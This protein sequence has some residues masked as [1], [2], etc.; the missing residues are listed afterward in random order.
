MSRDDHE[1]TMA[2]SVIGP[3]VSVNHYE[4]IDKIGA[5][6]MGEIFLAQD[7]RLA[8]KVA[9][10]FLPLS[11]CA[12]EL[13]KQRFIRE[14]R[15]AASL[16]HQNVITIFEVSEHDGRPFICMEYVKGKSLRQV[17]DEQTMN[18]A[19]LIDLALQICEG[20]GAAH[21]Q[22]IVHRDIKPEN[23]LLSESGKVKVLD[24]GLAVLDDDDKLTKT[25]TALGTAGYMSPEQAQGTAVDVRSDI[26]SVG[27]VVYELLSSKGPFQRDN[28]PATLHAI[29]YEDPPPLPENVKTALP[30]FQNVIEKALAKDLPHRYQSINELLSDLQSLSGGQPVTLYSIPR[31]VA[32]PAPASSPSEH[33]VTSLAVLCLRNLGPSEDDFLSFGITEDLIVDLTRVGTLRV[34]SMRSV[35][36]YKDL[37]DISE[38]ANRLNVIYVIDGSLHKHGDTIR[39][40]VQ[41]I[42][43]S[44]DQNV[45]AERWE[46]DHSELPHIKKALAEGISRA[47]DV[48]PEAAEAAQLG[49]TMAV[50]PQAYEHYLRGKFTFAQ[51]QDSSD[52]SIALE[53]YRQAL[54]EEPT[55]LAAR[56]GIAE[57]HL[58]NGDFEQARSEIHSAIEVAR[59]Q[60]LKAE[61]ASLLRLLANSYIGSS[62]W[63]DA[64][65]C[66][67]SSL[68]ISKSMGNLAGEAETLAVMIA[69][70]TRRAKFQK[71][72]NLFSRVLEINKQLNDQNKAAD[73]MKNMGTVHM[74]MGQYDKARKLY[75]EAGELASRRK[76]VSLEADCVGN[77]G[78]TY[79]HTGQFDE[80]L[81]CYEQALKTHEQLGNT[82]RMA[83]WHN[84]IAMVHESRG[85][86]RKAVKSFEMAASIDSSGDRARS[87]LSEGN[88]AAMLALIGD[89][90][91]ATASA[92]SALEVAREL[93]YPLLIVTSLDNLGHIS[94]WGGNASEAADYFREAI[95]TAHDAELILYEA[96][97]CSNY[98]EVLFHS[99]NYSEA[100]KLFERSTGLAKEIG[101]CE[102]QLKANAYIIAS[103]CTLSGWDGSCIDR[104]KGILAEA[105]ELGD[106]RYIIIVS[107][108]LGQTLLL[109]ATD[110]H[111]RAQGRDCL[112]EAYD[113]ANDRDIAHECRWVSEILGTSL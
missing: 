75:S 108:L 65:S 44:S 56:A 45:W 74:R 72:L 48:A 64:W 1:R 58:H 100:L 41:L 91:T 23:I 76:D 95:K 31:A 3:G 79:Y 83:L 29:V 40:S 96:A 113:L 68:E 34:P 21:S 39:V 61:E 66:A 106:P 47:L 18:T 12:D 33:G 112:K 37:D 110:E 111:E 14:A 30:G 20:L 35:L 15:S 63:D 42:E 82:S 104:M 46:R 94:Y 84:N 99:G 80:A 55:L 7:T 101:N 86:Y 6:G 11:H 4:V 88:V 109:Y 24:F 2:F 8:R 60:G 10:K 57:V 103:R 107:R 38:I 52:V 22:G 26:F 32:S 49:K 43:A 71:A 53:L 36:K 50:N 102:S 67:L 51:K 105:H 5:G 59:Q 17:I 78:L 70:L 69:I 97:S 98:G 28:L 87:A 90:K 9:L 27:A 73:A 92:H 93:D 81:K 19:Q 62:M 13:F 89:F 85:E 16:S 25:G 54:A 77:T